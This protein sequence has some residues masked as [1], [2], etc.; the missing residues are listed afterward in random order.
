MIK[1]VN[2]S[3]KY[4]DRIVLNNLSFEVTKGECLAIV[5]PSGSGKTTCLKLINRLLE[6]DS[7]NIYLSSLNIQ[8]IDILELR[9][10]V[11]YLFQGGLL[12]PHLSVFENISLPI[13]HQDKNRIKKRVGE[14]LKFVELKPEEFSGRLPRELSGGQMQRVSLAQILAFDPSIILLDEPFTGLDTE[15]KALLAEKIKSMKGSKT[16]ILVSHDLELTGKLA[17]RTLDL[18][19]Q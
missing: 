16:I 1:F 3:K 8:E 13:K 7:G 18:A 11:A 10:Q 14:L 19:K 15:T 12:F 17:N 5:G 9:S 6:A 2:V 4:G